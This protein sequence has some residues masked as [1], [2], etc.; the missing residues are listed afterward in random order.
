MV[1]LHWQ[2]CYHKRMIFV[3]LAATFV[4][5]FASFLL[6]ILFTAPQG[7]M[8]IIALFFLTFFLAASTCATLIAMGFR[9]FLTH[10][11]MKGVQNK[12]RAHEYAKSFRRGF[13]FG[14]FAVMLLALETANVFTWEVGILALAFFAFLEAYMIRKAL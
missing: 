5:S 12:T 8:V 11:R 6:L 7:G 9:F 2:K 13:L 10:R 4:V 3:G 1:E 14:A